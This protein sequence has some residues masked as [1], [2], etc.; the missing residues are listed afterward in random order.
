METIGIDLHQKRS[1]YVMVSQDERVISKRTIPS[2]PAAFRETFSALDAS[3]TRVALEA[4]IHW[5]WAVDIF[6]ELGMDVHLANPHKVRLIA[7]NTIKTDTVDAAA[8]AQLLRMNWLPES[9]ITPQAM[10]LLRERLR[11][12][13]TLVSMRTA[14]KRRSRTCMARRVA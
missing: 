12:R 3:S 7:E 6:E 9:R 8:L 1:R 5:Y 14:L 13:I 10:R 4:T 11:Y 2:T